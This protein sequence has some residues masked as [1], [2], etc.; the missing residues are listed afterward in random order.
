MNKRVGNGIG[1]KKAPLH[2]QNVSDLSLIFKNLLFSLSLSLHPSIIE[3]V[4][5]LTILS[6]VDLF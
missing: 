6:E 5:W 2:P 4:Y 3:I 1:S